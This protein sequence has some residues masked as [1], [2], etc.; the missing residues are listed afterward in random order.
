MNKKINIDY[1]GVVRELRNG[2]MEYTEV[3]IL[4][5]YDEIMDKLSQ[6]DDKKEYNELFITELHDRFY[7]IFK[8]IK[9]KKCYNYCL[10]HKYNES[11]IDACVYP[12][13]IILFDQPNSLDIINKIMVDNNWKEATYDQLF[14]VYNRSHRID[15][16]KKMIRYLN[17]FNIEK[18][19]IGLKCD[20]SNKMF[21]TENRGFTEYDYKL[22]NDISFKVKSN[23]CYGNSSF[24]FVNI[25]YKDID[26]LPYS[27]VVT[28]YYANMA[29]LIKYTRSYEMERENW[30]RALRFVVETE[31]GRAHV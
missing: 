23:F 15:L 30:E 4:N 13:F 17:A 3:P 1:I 5:P 25:T 11:Y 12:K 10:P 28:Y 19:I 2:K 18:T 24:F 8:Y 20:P 6:V 9:P 26:I 29:D 27:Q 14:E 7:K 31:I 22:N 16:C 21:S